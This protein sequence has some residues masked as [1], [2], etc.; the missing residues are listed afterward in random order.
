MDD[1]RSFKALAAA[2]LMVQ[3]FGLRSVRVFK[4]WNLKLGECSIKSEH[5]YKSRH[6]KTLLDLLRKRWLELYH[7][8]KKLPD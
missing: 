7:A 5:S 6:I 1:I 3:Y 8:A 4:L 2:I